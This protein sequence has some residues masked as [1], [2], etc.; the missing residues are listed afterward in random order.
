M[1]AIDADALME[2]YTDRM[3]KLGAYYGPF[4]SECGVLSG[5]MKLLCMQPT[6]S[7]EGKKGKWIWEGKMP[8]ERCR[9]SECG[10]YR[11]LK[12]PEPDYFCP[13]CGAKMEEAEC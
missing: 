9:C 8:L 5:A 11:Q 12:I 7:P 6:I 13:N 4:A 3:E 10:Y 2:I 1:R